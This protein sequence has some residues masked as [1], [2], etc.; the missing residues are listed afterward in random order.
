[1]K[2]KNIFI[3]IGLL[4]LLHWILLVINRI[5]YNILFNLLWICHFTLLIA[6]SGFIKRNNFI[7][8]G[9]L[10]SVLV[11]Q[12]S[13]IIDFISLSLTGNS[14]FGFTSYLPDY[15]LYGKLLTFHHIY[16]SPLLLWALWKQK[17][18]SKYGWILAASIFALLSLI[19]FIFV[20]TDYNVNCV[21]SICDVVKNIIPPI[22]YLD[23]LSPVSH[24]ILLNI[25]VDVI[26][27]FL[28]NMI[29]YYIFKR[30]FSNKM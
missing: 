20:P 16:L 22:S 26:V 24:L 4:L 9:S 1:M 6:A 3:Y 5:N 18:I 25:I 7:L 27:F 11:F 30:K 21:H 29:F 8:S 14:L 10:V 28:V 19:T 12:V 17:K 15:S 23:N 13:W 2:Q